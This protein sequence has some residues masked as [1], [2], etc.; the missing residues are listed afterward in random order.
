MTTVFEL[1]KEDF[2]NELDIIVLLVNTHDKPGR[3]P[4]VR[5]AAA[6]SA[7]L[8]VAAT[9][10]E[11][12]RQSAREYA[13]L[14]VSNANS[15]AELPKD[16]CLTAWK[17]SMKRLG[18]VRFNIGDQRIREAQLLEARTQFLTIH[19][20]IGGDRSKDVFEDLVQNENNLRPTELNAMF[21]VSGLTDVC[22]ALCDKQPMQVHF[23]ET[24]TKKIHGKLV[25]SLDEFIERR[26][27]IAHALDP[28][29]STGTD[30]IIKDINMLKALAE[31]LGQVL[32]AP[33]P[34]SE[35]K[36]TRRPVLASKLEISDSGQA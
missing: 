12:I 32:D 5:V 29:T 3:P 6:N 16:L 15:I 1:I 8:L 26:N 28:K 19:E 23:Q 35:S 33:V 34:R 30:Q 31:S 2:I 14:V 10:E 25:L 27:K 13:R 21:K 36:T 11:Y 9:F 20:F 22:L 17:R 24:D 18:Q 4:K 7:T